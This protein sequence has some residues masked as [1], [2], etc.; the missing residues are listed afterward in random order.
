VKVKY[1]V[2][3]TKKGIANPMKQKVEHNKH[4]GHIGTKQLPGSKQTDRNTANQ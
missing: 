4:G 3:L 2:V 1:I